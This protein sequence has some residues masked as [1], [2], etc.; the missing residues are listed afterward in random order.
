MNSPIGAKSRDVC[1]ELVTGPAPAS[2]K[3][4]DCVPTRTLNAKLPIIS[5]RGRSA[6]NKG[7]QQGHRQSSESV[8][9]KRLI[10]QANGGT[11]SFEF[12]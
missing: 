3:A 8:L 5:A 7:E 4:T 6:Q 11:L 9:A 2:T 12:D 1:S 10:F